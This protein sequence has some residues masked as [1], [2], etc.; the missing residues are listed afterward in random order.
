LQRYV[1][2]SGLS[3]IYRTFVNNI[4][5]LVEPTTYEQACHGPNW[6]AAMN[7]EIQAL[8]ENKTWSMVPLPLG[9][10]PIGCNCKWVF[11]I[12]YHADGTI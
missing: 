1:S 2:Y 7:S 5:L 10:R 3:D 6:V 11:K 4:S 9:Q 12:K 8:E